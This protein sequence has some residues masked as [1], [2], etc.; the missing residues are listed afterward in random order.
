MTKRLMAIVFVL[1]AASTS[2]EPAISAQAPSAAPPVAA[3]ATDLVAQL[4][5]EVRALRTELAEATRVSITSQLLTARLQLQEQRLMH[6]DQQRSAATAKRIDAEKMRTMFAT[7]L[8]Q[9]QGAAGSNDA[10]HDPK[11]LESA[12]GGLESQVRAFQTSETSFR[13][14]EDALLTAISA[15]QA[16]WSEFNSRLYELERSLPRSR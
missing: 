16:R 6:L 1:L 4:L 15:E 8:K 2:S 7:Q 5:A 14:E 9:F 11:E 13:A 3:A 10:N 12:L